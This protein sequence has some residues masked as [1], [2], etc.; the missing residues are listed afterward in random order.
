M[1]ANDTQVG[2]EHYKS[3]I[4]HWD[5][6][7]ANDI[8]YMEAQIIK[9]VT[10]WRKKNGFQDLAKAKHFLEK[11]MEHHTPIAPPPTQQTEDAFIPICPVEFLGHHKWSSMYRHG[12]DGRMYEVFK[13]DL[14][15]EEREKV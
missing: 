14:C 10:R 15:Q 1:N 2:G 3:P 13:C 6:V 7:L 4:Q 12:T 5:Y 11:L 8:P 9:Y